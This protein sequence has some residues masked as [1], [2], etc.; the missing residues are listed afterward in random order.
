MKIKIEVKSEL[1]IEFDENSTEFKELFENY[2][3]Y[4][5]ECCDYEEFAEIIA[6]HIARFGI[7]DLIE[8]VGFVKRN[9]KKQKDYLSPDGVV[10]EYDNPINVIAD[11]TMNG[12]L[13]YETY[14]Y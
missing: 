13:D 4:F 11:F 12:V 14:V 7:E 1:E 3:K 5:I 10:R 6:S 9:G 2:N 8:G